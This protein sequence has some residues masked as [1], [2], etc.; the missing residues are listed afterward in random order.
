MGRGRATALGSG[1]EGVR[2]NEK[3]EAVTLE[4]GCVEPGGQEGEVQ[5]GREAC[6]RPHP[7]ARQHPRPPSGAAGRWADGFLGKKSQEGA[8]TSWKGRFLKA[9]G[10]RASLSSSSG[11]SKEGTVFMDGRRPK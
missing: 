3:R 11:R 1:A 8:V 9:P 10:G 2:E 5:P 4:G 6:T 7:I